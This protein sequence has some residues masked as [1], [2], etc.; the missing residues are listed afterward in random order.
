MTYAWLNTWVIGTLTSGSLFLMWISRSVKRWEGRWSRRRFLMTPR[1]ILLPF[2]ERIEAWLKYSHVKMTAKQWFGLVVGS[3][4]GFSSLGI[5]L[6]SMGVAGAAAG[7]YFSGSVIFYPFQ[8]RKKFNLDMERQ[9]QRTKRMLAKLYARHVNT[10]EML[11][12]L[13][14]ALEDGAFKNHVVQA[15]QRTKTTDTLGDAIQ[16][17]SD[18]IQRPSLQA[19]AAVL[20]QGTHYANLPLDERLAHMATK[21]RE[22]ALI[23]HEKLADQTRLRAL[24][25]AGSFIALPL[26]ALL[27]VFVFEYVFKAFATIQL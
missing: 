27:A 23:Q 17:M 22:K 18:E 20:V 16:W 13:T 26:I 15:I 1:Q 9:I 21:D 5:L 4:M 3:L 24:V 8:K 12:I 6:P 2:E 11:P 14:D 7:L 25:E 10:D 19:L